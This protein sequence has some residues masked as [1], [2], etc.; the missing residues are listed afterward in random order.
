MTCWREKKIRKIAWLTRSSGSLT[1]EQKLANEK[2][3]KYLM[4]IANSGTQIDFYSGKGSTE[5]KIHEYFEFMKGSETTESIFDEYM[6]VPGNAKLTIEAEQ[7][8]YDAVITS[9]GNDPGIDVL[10]EA[11]K[12]PVIGLGDAGMHMCSLISHRFCRLVT[13]RPGRHKIGRLSF[14]NYNGL[15]KWVSSRSIGLSVPELRI[16][17]EKTY[18]A[19]LKQGKIAKEQDQADAITWSCSGL[20]SMEGLDERLMEALEIP[21]VNPWKA[22]VRLAEICIDFGWRHS[23]L[24]YP[25]PKWKFART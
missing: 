14:E 4:S 21:V 18:K 22:G 8:G 10:R 9:C 12:I 23:K 25:S 16:D 3:R 7:D 5:I 13:Y 6:G 1:P 24:T 19:C 11:V 20:S 15:M 2:R 17:H